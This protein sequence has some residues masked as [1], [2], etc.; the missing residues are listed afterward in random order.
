M[1]VLMEELTVVD[2]GDNV[3]TDSGALTRGEEN[4]INT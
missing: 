3:I 2:D 4:L 1:I